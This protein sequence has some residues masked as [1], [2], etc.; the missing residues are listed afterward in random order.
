MQ[1]TDPIAD[2]LTRI[3]NG[4]QARHKRVD[5]PSSNLKKEI[6]RILAEKKYIAGFSEIKDSRQ[7]ILRIALKYT[8]GVSAISGLQRISRPGL[9]VYVNADNLPR[10]M[11][12]LGVAMVSTSKGIL[13][14]RD[15]AT[16][17][18]GGE[19]LCHIW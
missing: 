4:I 8:G 18:V 6:S 15:A 12:G 16:T 14:D 2:Y 10:V 19:V 5:I 13:T 9:R 3:R 17:R 1:T 11:N 7:G